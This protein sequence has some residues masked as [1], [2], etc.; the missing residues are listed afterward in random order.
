M[1]DYG[2]RLH[3][4]LHMGPAKPK[5]IPAELP[6]DEDVY[7]DQ[8]SVE[9][10]N[11]LAGSAARRPP[12]PLGIKQWLMDTGCGH[13]LLDK[14]SV[15]GVMQRVEPSNNKIGLQTAS[16]YIKAESQIELRIDELAETAYPYVL[17]STTPPVLSI[18]RRVMEGGYSFIWKAGELP[19][20][21]T[22]NKRSLCW[23]C[24]A[25]S[26]T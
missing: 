20:M 8:L 24:R 16:G 26:P 15:Q 5:L 11:A 4:F 18:G 19:Y 25:T 17:S 1:S 22:P 21:V 13:D 10:G 9:T 3:D 7:D 2:S 6:A 23:G 12:I 14:R